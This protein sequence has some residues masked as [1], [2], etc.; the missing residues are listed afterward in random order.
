[1]KKRIASS[2]LCGV[3]FVLWV[4]AAGAF[5]RIGEGG[6]G[7]SANSYSWS[8]LP[9]N[10]DLYVGTNR[11]H[12]HSMME[13]L[14][15]MPGSP[16]SPD[17]LPA[18]L[19][20]DPPAPPPANVWFTR[21][22]ASAF[23]GEIW[24]YNKQKQWERVHQSGIYQIPDGSGRWVPFAYGYRALAEFKGYLYA[25]GIGT[26]M[27]PVPYNTILRSASGDPGPWEDVSRNIRQTTNIRAIT[28]WNGKLYVAV[29][30]N[31]GAVVFASEDPGTQ[32]WIPVSVPGFGGNNSEI[33]YLT[34]FNNHLYASTVNLVTGFEV[35]KTDGT[36]DP[37]NPGKYAW[38]RVIQNGFGDTWNQYGMTMAA[39]G[40]YLYVGTAVG[41]GMVMKDGGVVG[42]RAIEII[43]VDKDDNAE[44]IVGAREA[45]DPIDGGPNPRIPL[46]GMGAGF[47]NPFNVYAWNM[48]VYK[49]CLYVG[50]FDLSVFLIGAL[51]KD[52]SLIRF[53][54][55]I[56]A[57]GDLDFPESIVDAIINSRFTP[58]VLELM[59]KLFGGG[60]LWKSCD[61]V[62]WMP[63]TLNGFGNPLNYG[64]RE[65]IPVRKDGRDKALAIGTANPFTGRPNGGCEVWLD[66]FDGE[67]GWA[68]GPRYT[69][70]GNWATYTPYERIAKTVN[71]YAGQTMLAGKVIFSEPSADDKVTITI[72]LKPGWFFN[73]I[74]DNVKIQDYATTPPSRN[75]SPGQFAR[76]RCA[77]GCSF[78]MKVPANRFYGV[79]VD[80]FHVGL[81]H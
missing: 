52:P 1:M 61:G 59:K 74:S 66:G 18:D 51:E 45:S 31:E 44:L 49:N 41:I 75:P 55:S 23:Q 11:H 4:T 2:I 17:M 62:H 79:H 19:L 16:I 27:P 38:T 15:Y 64:I 46:S 70:K 60:D 58:E 3:F 35:W 67:S 65:V 8:V 78:S 40:D 56:Y 26:W 53:F 33:Y 71:L 76:K 7:D 9:F 28:E 80:L 42:T 77:Y 54:M 34:V 69:T 13:A 48:N 47:G 63:M 37:Y 72:T 39:F 12:L 24:R 36:D 29:S 25:C 73:N 20:P 10:G 21:E 22:W 14:S 30:V 68:Y 6:F 57:P 32:D 81:L 5:V 43:R 50:T